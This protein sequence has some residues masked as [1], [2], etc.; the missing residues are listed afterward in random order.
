M[1][2]A[3]RSPV[4]ELNM[5][6][7][8]T[9]FV[10]IALSVLVLDQVTKILV[11]AQLILGESVSVIPGVFHLSLVRNSGMAFGAVFL[12]AES[13]TAVGSVS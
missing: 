11:S 12:C 5:K 9:G 10:V 4:E 7:F 2:G 8:R 3:I 6:L 1:D 13:L